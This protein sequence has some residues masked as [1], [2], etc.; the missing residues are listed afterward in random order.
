[1]KTPYFVSNYRKITPE[2]NGLWI[3]ADSLV[4]IRSDFFIAKARRTQRN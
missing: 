4:S 3:Q 1:M 2:V